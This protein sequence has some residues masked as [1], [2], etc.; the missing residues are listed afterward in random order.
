MYEFTAYD[1]V[2]NAP[3]LM[4]RFRDR[5]VDRKLLKQVGLMWNSLLPQYK[6]RRLPTEEI[7]Q[8]GIPRDK[9]VFFYSERIR[10]LYAAS[11]GSVVDYVGQLEPW[12][13]IDAYLFDGT[14]DWV[15]VITHEDAILCL[16]L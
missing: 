11:F 16:G 8:L 1:R 6:P 12:E 15:V 7:A 4:E 9:K 5:Y 14:M 10:T 2:L 13:D 3:W